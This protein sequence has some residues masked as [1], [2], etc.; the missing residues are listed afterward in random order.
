MRNIL[1]YLLDRSNKKELARINSDDYFEEPP[2][3]YRTAE[4]I[5]RIRWDDKS[6]KMQDWNEGKRKENI[7][8]CSDAKLIV[9]YRYC[10]EH[11]YD[12]CCDQCELE[13][14]RRGWTLTKLKDYK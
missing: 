6:R 3:S 5:A 7:K 10:K 13:A 1:E 9:Y 8:A 12:T 2:M 14:N 11:K 4:S